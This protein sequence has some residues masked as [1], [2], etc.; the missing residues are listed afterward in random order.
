MPHQ[1]T[2]EEDVPVPK[3]SATLDMLGNV[4]D[5]LRAL[6]WSPAK[7][8]SDTHGLRIHRSSPTHRHRG[9]AGIGC[10]QSRYRDM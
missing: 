3:Q 10:P 5:F 9:G 1:G 2:I 8:S 4:A 7:C 6:T